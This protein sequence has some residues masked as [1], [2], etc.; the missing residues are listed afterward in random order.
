M[1]L[2]KESKNGRLAIMTG[3]GDCPGLNAVIRAAVHRLINH[4]HR[5]VVGLLDSF[6]GIL[7]NPIRLQPLEIASVSG[8]LSK[9][10]TILGTTN[11]GDPFAFPSVKNDGALIDCSDLLISRLKEAGIEGIIA[12]GGDGTL[13]ICHK[14]MQK[15]GIGIVGVP[16]TI[17]NDVAATDFTFG[18]WTAADTATEAISK[19]HSTA[20][21]HDRIM[22]VEIM[23]RNA[24]HLALHAGIAGGADAILIPEI[25]Y[26]LDKVAAKIMR[27]KRFGSN[28]SI[29]AVAEGAY[30]KNGQVMTEDLPDHQAS[31]RMVKLGG[32]ARAVARGLSERTGME[33]RVTV[34]GHLQRGGSPNAFDR[35]LSSSFGVAAAD[36]AAEADFGTMMALRTPNIVRVP[37]EDGLQENRKVDLKGQAIQSARGVGICLGDPSE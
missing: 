5:E 32:I 25:P 4:H 16:K 3:G 2:I 37:L 20:E 14:L 13:G 18:F 17:D 35:V 7:E 9:G 31:G 10:G 30:P 8:I 33:S 24:G 28:F 21:S 15:S 12:I 27:R 11:R 29:I 36:A 23:G 26:D 34:L 6:N 19:L 1:T 22:V